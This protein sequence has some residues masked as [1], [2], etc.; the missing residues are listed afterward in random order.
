MTITAA[1]PHVL[2]KD[3][4][5]ITM[6]RGFFKDYI[7]SFHFNQNQIIFGGI[8][9]S[10]MKFASFIEFLNNSDVDKMYS[11]NEVFIEVYSYFPDL[12][13]EIL[14]NEQYETN[15]NDV[16]FG[17]IMDEFTLFQDMRKDIKEITINKQKS[18]NEKFIK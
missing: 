12:F 14:H 16:F 5:L 1:S 8:F 7:Y 13:V 18:A 2:T 15:I 9:S 10:G 17:T 6:L 3:S 4:Q 11:I